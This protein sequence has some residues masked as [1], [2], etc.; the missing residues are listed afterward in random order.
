MSA[1]S[2]SLPVSIG[3]L[4]RMTHFGIFR[5]GIWLIDVDDSG[6]WDAGDALLFWGQTGDIPVVGDWNGDGR[7]K[8]GVFRNGVWWLDVNG[9]GSWDTGDRT[10]LWGQAGDLPVYGNW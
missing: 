7:A 1:T 10:V 6:L 2:G 3:A 5:S 8:V 4:A 9:N